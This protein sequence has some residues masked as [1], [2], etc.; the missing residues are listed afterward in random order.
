MAARDVMDRQPVI[1]DWYCR[2]MLG[3]ALAEVWLAEDDLTQAGTEA[4]RFLALTLATA[5]RTWQALAWEASTRVA[6][7]ED[8]HHRAAEETRRR[9]NV[10]ASFPAP[11]SSS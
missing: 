4:E 3:Q 6:M 7:A 8:D 1:H 10:T 5:E 11:Q 9:P 2:M